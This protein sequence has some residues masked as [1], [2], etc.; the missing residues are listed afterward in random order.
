MGVCQDNNE[1][2]VKMTDGVPDWLLS[3]RQWGFVGLPKAGSL[4]VA[5]TKFLPISPSSS[6]SGITITGVDAYNRKLILQRQCRWKISFTTAY[7]YNLKPLHCII[8]SPL[9]SRGADRLTIWI[10]PQT[11]ACQVFWRAVR[12]QIFQFLNAF[13]FLFKPVERVV[14]LVH[15]WSQFIQRVNDHCFMFLLL[16]LRIY[17]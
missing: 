12:I 14:D 9:Q 11:I 15:N 8:P 3:R 4:A 10:A 6:P 1:D 17:C 2:A 16:I 13:S 5:T 7:I